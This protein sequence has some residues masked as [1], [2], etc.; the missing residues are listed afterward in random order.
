[1]EIPQN[2]TKQQNRSKLYHLTQISQNSSISKIM[3]WVFQRKTY[4]PLLQHCLRQLK[5]IQESCLSTP[6]WRKYM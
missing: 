1:M 6:E 3:K 4:V 5:W 2:K